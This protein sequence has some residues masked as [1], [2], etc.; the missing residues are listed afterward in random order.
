M[1]PT[2][3]TR[4]LVAR[5]TC[6]ALPAQRSRVT[7]TT[8]T[9]RTRAAAQADKYYFDEERIG[10]TIQTQYRWEAYKQSVLNDA[11]RR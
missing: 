7:L 4:R 10:K 6:R 5:R 3:R 8:L 9:T 11:L 2:A 1:R